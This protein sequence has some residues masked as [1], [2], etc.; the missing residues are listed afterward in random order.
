MIVTVKALVITR[1]YQLQRADPHSVDGEGCLQDDILSSSAGALYFPLN[2]G[3]EENQRCAHKLCLGSKPNFCSK[4]FVFVFREVNKRNVKWN[5]IVFTVS[6]NI[7]AWRY[8]RQ[9]LH[10]NYSYN[11]SSR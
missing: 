2:H 9:F 6:E 1:I 4:T 10:Y 5:K 8:V 11:D 3:K 7:I